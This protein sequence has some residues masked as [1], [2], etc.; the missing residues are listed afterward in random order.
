MVIHNHLEIILITYNR[1]KKLEGTLQ[2]LLSED[3]PVKECSITI[4][5]NASTDGTNELIE[6]FCARYPNIKHIRRP[7]NA[8]ADANTCM[9]YELAS[10]EYL[11]VLCDDDKYDWTDW[12][13]VE[14]AIEDKAPS[15]MVSHYKIDAAPDLSDPAYQLRFLTYVP[16]HIF[17]TELLSCSIMANMYNTIYT[18]FPQLIL[19]VYLIN[20]GMK[21][22]Y[23][24]SCIVTEDRWD[25]GDIS[26]FRGTEK[27][28]LIPRRRYNSV[29]YG[30]A[31]QLINLYDEELRFR[32]MRLTYGEY[33]AHRDFLDALKGQLTMTKMYNLY[34]D[35][36]MCLPQEDRSYL[37]RNSQHSL[38]HIYMLKSSRYR[39][40]LELFGKFKIKLLSVWRR[41]H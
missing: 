21:I 26:W 14:K 35:V 15:I 29:I 40:F 13:T 24:Q 23:T 39:I 2:S 19:P 22:R 16:G 1:K 10:K 11:W 36:Y 17:R 25:S 12:P 9:A 27:N 6:D 7:R 5:N 37:D 4:L 31:A 38:F 34:A 41:K 3:S 20:N 8:G 28:E 32:T 18:L 33:Y 30:I